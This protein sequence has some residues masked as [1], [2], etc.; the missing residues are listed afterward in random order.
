MT[1]RDRDAKSLRPWSHAT[2]AVHVKRLSAARYRD[3]GPLLSTPSQP[4]RVVTSHR[5]CLGRQSTV[6]TLYVP[7]VGP[8]EQLPGGPTLGAAKVEDLPSDAAM[9]WGAA[10]SS[11]IQDGRPAPTLANDLRLS[12]EGRRRHSAEVQANGG[13]FEAPFRRPNPNIH[14]V[15]AS[16]RPHRRRP[17]PVSS[18]C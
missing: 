13:S 14:G 2:P 1:G 8:T 12:C 4:M 16:G 18:A 10:G 3:E 17:S 9:R 11:E 5:P 7:R 15:A 6:T